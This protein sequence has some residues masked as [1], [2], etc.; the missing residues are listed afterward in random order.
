M[1]TASFYCP[2]CKAQRLFQ[3]QTMSH[4][5]HILASVFLCGLWLPIWILLALSDN[6][7]FRCHMCGFTDQIKYLNDPLLRAQESEAR[8]AKISALKEQ[9]VAGGSK[10][11]A[12][13]L[14]WE[15]LD[16]QA[17]L[18]I[19][20]GLAVGLPFLVASLM[21]VSGK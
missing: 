11:A 6:Q 16:Q 4:T 18:I 1:K 19:F 12:F 14:W 10:W 21:A 7:P 17:R 3:Q 20:L 2:Q 5:P 9:S 13:R 8:Q 15:Q